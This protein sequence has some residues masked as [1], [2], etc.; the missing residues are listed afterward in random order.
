MN[1]TLLSTRKL[2]IVLSTFILLQLNLFNTNAQVNLYNVSFATGVVPED[3]NGF[4]LLIGSSQDNA[5]SPLQN[6]G[7]NFTYNNIVYSQYSV[8]S[9][10]LM[11]LGSTLVSTNAVNQLTVN[12]DFPK[13][14]PYWDDLNTA[15]A[16]YCGSKMIGVAPNRKLSIEWLL[17]VPKNSANTG[18]IQVWL[19]ETTNVIQFVYSTGMNVNNGG[20]S[21]GLAATTTDYISVSPGGASP[22]FSKVIETNNNITAITSGAS[23]IFTPPVLPPSCI[24][25]STPT[26]TGNSNAV[27]L[28]WTPGSGDP[29]SYDVYFGTTSNPPLVSVSQIATTYNPGALAY[30]TTYFYKIV[31]KNGAGPASGCAVNQFSTATGINYDVNRTTGNTFTSI[32]G[33]GTSASGWRN[34]T[35][36]D[37]NLST[38]QPIGFNFPYQGT[39]YSNFSV[40]TNGFITFNVGTSNTGGGNGVYSYTNGLNAVGG[41]LIV[42]PFYEDLVCQGNS[43]AQSS[44]D[45]SMKYAVSGVVGSR[46]LTVEWTGMEIYNNAGPN[47]N[48]QLKLYEATGDID[49]IY[50]TMEGFNGTFNYFYSYSVG[51]NGINISNPVLNAEYIHQMNANTRNFGNS[52]SSQLVEVP[53][54]NSAL[55]FT[56]GVYL[57]YVLATLPPVNDQKTSPQHLDVNTSTCTE[58]CGT[59]YSSANATPTPAMPACSSGNADDDV[60]FEFTATNPNTT[61]KVLSGGNY[62]AAVELYNSSNTLLLCANVSGLGLTE[63]LSPTTL[64]T[65][66]Q[67]FLRI[68]HAQSGSGS[69]AGQF[70]VCISATA[71]PPI[72]DNC[73]AAISLPVVTGVFTTGSQTVAA[74]ASASIPLCS[75][76][77]TIPDD[78]VWY[79]FIATNTTEI[80]TVS[81]GTGFNAVV[82]LFSGTCGALTSIQCVNNLGNGQTEV[83][84]ANNL[85][86]NQTYYIRVYHSGVGGGTGL[87]SINVST[88]LPA[89][90]GNTSPSSPTSD[91]S[92]SGITLKWSPVANANSYTVYM[93]NVNP[94][95][96]ILINTTDTTAI[97]GPLNQ[98]ESYYWQVRAN[99]TAGASQSCFVSTFA[100]VPFDYALRVK[101]FVEAMYLSN[102]TMY[103]SLVPNDTLCDSIFVGLASPATKQILWSTKTILNTTGTASALFPQPALGQS[104]YIVVKHR[105]SLETWSQGT[106]AFN[107]PDTIYDFSNAAGKA[108][109][110]NQVEVQPGIFA[111]HSG[112]I[113]QDGFINALDYVTTDNSLGMGFITGY[114]STDV[115]GDGILES[116]DYSFIENK[117]RTVRIVLHP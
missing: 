76:P 14:A 112:D 109:G 51:L 104:Y 94:P 45:G 58:L 66:Q 53:A 74:T 1:R 77:G 71:I 89:C 28:N 22:S 26:G 73:A 2:R 75:A 5:V 32:L 31:P 21:V 98:G 79:S 82:Q 64:V 47:L 115:N 3:M 7:F 57:P 4:N 90:P 59:Y 39:T 88:S 35:N 15:A 92:Q 50:G 72:N 40:S 36:T 95:T 27:Q 30:N 49:F 16:G 108:F 41:T 46:I 69:G 107:A 85:T 78:D 8:N 116:S 93:E 111:I 44:L 25:S 113:N 17:A 55:K 67:Y 48:F 80:V 54:C 97:T 33:T 117:T 63:T 103:S 62:D 102:G 110:N 101:V 18:R 12:S 29:T 81:G 84:T 70:S 87:F 65:G 60:W 6:I 20:Y 100:T 68:Y 24:L 114:I 61:I 13:I 42:A 106:F 9:N 38:S 34:G 10:G 37:D 86:K 91:V 11:R 19:Y 105:N 52:P 56:P 43:G 23:V 83:L 99:N 96:Q